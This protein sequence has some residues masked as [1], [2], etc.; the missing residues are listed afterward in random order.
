MVFS[1]IMEN[2]VDIL[3]ERWYNQPKLRQQL[4]GMMQRG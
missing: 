2:M 3:P 1:V 4:H